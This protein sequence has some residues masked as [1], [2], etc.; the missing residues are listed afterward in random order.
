MDYFKMKQHINPDGSMGGLVAETAIVSKDTFLDISSQVLHFANIQKKSKIGKN[1]II[2]NYAHIS[3][4]IIGNNNI[5]SDKVSIIDSLIEDNNIICHS[6]QMHNSSIGDGFRLNC[7]C[8]LENT[9]LKT[10]NKILIGTL[11]NSSFTIT[12]NYF[13]YLN[14][15]RNLTLTEELYKHLLLIMQKTL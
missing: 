6:T 3:N 14:Y 11:N 13:E 8:Y 2:R 9:I 15:K 7:D 4:S 5:I 12:K 10:G 1:C